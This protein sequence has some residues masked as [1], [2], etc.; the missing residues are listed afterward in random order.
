MERAH[1]RFVA[2]ALAILLLLSS[3]ALPVRGASF[4]EINASSVFLKQ[5]TNYTCTL[6]SAV[7]L[8]RRAAM[9]NGCADWASVT[10]TALR[11]TAWLEGA[12]LKHS[13]SYAGVS[14]GHRNQTFDRNSLAALLASHP[15]G[16]VAYNSGGNNQW[17]AILLTDYTD[18]VF[19]C[20]D[21]A[22]GGGRRPLSQS[23]I[24]ASGEDGKIALFKAYWYVTSSVAA[25]TPD[26]YTV[27]FNANGGTGAPGAQTKT[28]GVP[29][30]LS[31]VVPVREEYSFTGWNTADNGGGTAYA[32]GAVYTVDG[33]VT[34]Y[35]QWE[36]DP[37]NW[38]DANGDGKISNLDVVRLKNYLA[39]YDED[40]GAS[41]VRVFTAADANCDGSV[42]NQDVVRLKNYLANFDEDTGLSSVPLGPDLK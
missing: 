24:K 40:T 33:N 34:L 8:I 31:R 7:M 30:A 9:M 6:S 41:T 42:S 16:I 36:K 2:L 27:S 18:G 21:P 12:G 13:F 35:A 14:V 29:L 26:S 5:E 3:A 37:V 17:H 32:A 22:Y 20:A 19:Y 38:G 23:S 28:A 11:P 15:E 4:T 25:L 1:T 10:E 39:N